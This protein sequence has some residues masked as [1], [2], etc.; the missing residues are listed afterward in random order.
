MPLLPVKLRRTLKSG[1]LSFVLHLF[2]VHDYDSQL[3]CEVLVW[4][5]WAL[6][7]LGPAAGT[8]AVL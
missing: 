3:L 6:Q 1:V 8:S 7:T 4:L 5:G 2:S